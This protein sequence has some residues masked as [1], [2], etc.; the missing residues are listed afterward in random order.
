MEKKSLCEFVNLG[1]DHRSHKISFSRTTFANHL[2]RKRN[3][4][5]KK[6]DNDYSNNP[7]IEREKKITHISHDYKAFRKIRRKIRRLVRTFSFVR[8]VDIA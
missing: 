1:L 4:Q 3:T 2:R 6:L 8:V 7:E 5:R